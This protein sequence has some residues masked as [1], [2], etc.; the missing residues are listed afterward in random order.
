MVQQGLPGPQRLWTGSTQVYLLCPKQILSTQKKC[1]F[2]LTSQPHF[3]RFIL[4]SNNG[5]CKTYSYHD[6]LHSSV[7]N[8]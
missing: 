6:V 8:I 2:A 4:E 1:A 3:W 5:V 7:C